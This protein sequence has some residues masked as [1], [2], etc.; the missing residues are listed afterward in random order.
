MRQL[1]F[2]HGA[3]DILYFDAAPVEMEG[4]N[5]ADVVLPRQVLFGHGVDRRDFHDAGHFRREFV[6]H[7]TKVQA[8]GSGGCPELDQDGA[9]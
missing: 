8:M 2:G 1:G 9:G 3:R 5:A 7:G 6:Q 4:G